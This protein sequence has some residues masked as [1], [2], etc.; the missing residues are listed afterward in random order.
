MSEV[1]KRAWVVIPAYQEANVV[2][3]VVDG[4]RRF[5]S[6]V[7]VV[8]DGSTD[9]TAQE[10]LA[11][12]A[13]VLPH[14][15]NLGQGAALQTGIEYALARGAEFVFTFDADGQHAPESLAAMASTLERTGAEVVLGS[16]TLGNAENIPMARRLLLRAAVLFTWMHARLPVTDTHNGLRLFTRDAAARIRIAQARMAHASEILSEIRRLGL[17]FAEAPVTVR[18]TDYSLAKGQKLKDTVRILADLLYAR[19][20]RYV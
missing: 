4:V 3:R 13:T 19:W 11:A 8:D 12:G 7:V 1:L 14:V 17:R 16:R 6:R 20:A 10:A 5:A 2:R 9:E 18:Y 15:V